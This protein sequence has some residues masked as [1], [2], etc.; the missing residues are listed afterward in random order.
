QFAETF[1]R[2]SVRFCIDSENVLRE[3]QRAPSAVRD[4]VP[5]LLE[6]FGLLDGPNGTRPGEDSWLDELARTIYEASPADAAGAAAE[7]LSAGYSP[8][9]VGEAISLAANLLLLHDPGRKPEW[10]SAE[11]PAGCVH[12]DSVGVHASDAANAW[13]AIARVS[14]PRNR[15][16][17]LVVAAY[18]T[19]GQSARP[20]RDPF[21]HAVRIGE[22][23]ATDP[24]VLLKATRSAIQA[25]DQSLACALV[26]RYGEQSHSARPLQDLLL[27]Y[28]VSEDGAL[29]AEKYYCT[30]IEEFAT[31][32]PAFRWRQLVALARVTASEFGH[33]APGYETACQL[34]GVS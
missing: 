29:H 32:R 14:N 12:G 17:S 1:L 26:Q 15:A 24:D 22:A 13:R 5:R 18:H 31:M 10:A 6:K 4:V 21:P 9:A 8:E 30:A 33:P 34:L 11:K 2:Q 27:Q 20:S 25:G 28:A 19:A 16:A 23:T 3:K 7:A